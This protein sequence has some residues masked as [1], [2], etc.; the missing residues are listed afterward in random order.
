MSSSSDCGCC[1]TLSSPPLPP[2]PS[3][4]LLPHVRRALRDVPL[5][6]PSAVELTKLAPSAT[7]PRLRRGSSE[8]GEQRAAPL[9][10]SSAPSPSYASLALQYQ[11]ASQTIS[12]RLDE[13]VARKQTRVSDG[14]L[15]VDMAADDGE[16]RPFTSARSTRSSTICTRRLSVACRCWTTA[17]TGLGTF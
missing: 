14:Q 12:L 6:M 16:E 5:G 2:L 17:V 9:A 10:S 3:S 11:L 7:H 1:H 4:S 13:R 8:A 15:A